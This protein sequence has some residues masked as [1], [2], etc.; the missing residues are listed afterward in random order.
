[1]GARIG[2]IVFLSIASAACSGE[3]SK[4]RQEDTADKE[5]LVFKDD[6]ERSE[7]GEDWLDTGGG[8]RIVNGKLRAQGARNKPL[9]LRK[10]LPRDARV[11]FKAQPLSDDIDTKVELWGDGK[12]KATT[13]SYTATSY[14]VI[15]GGWGN[16]LS[17]IARMNEHGDDRKT[18]REPRGVKGKEYRFSIV[19]KGNRLAWSID[20]SP[21]L[22]M[23]DSEPLEGAGH[24]Y[25]AINNWESEVLF[26]D[27]AIYAM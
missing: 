20:G 26:D 16:R 8:Y 6:F 10:K 2:A 21:F 14:V 15:L 23:N 7:I 24:E 27:L 19:R 25:F 22:E 4:A 11:E 5:K 12:S 17:I 3:K 9:W 18:R 1:M 13:L